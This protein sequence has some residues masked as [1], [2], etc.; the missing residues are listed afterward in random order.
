MEH[1]WTLIYKGKEK[2]Y[3][4]T[5]HRLVGG[6]WHMVS[7]SEWSTLADALNHIQKAQVK[8]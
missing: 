8:A 4:L 3:V 6:D 5:E 2:L 1:K 7:A